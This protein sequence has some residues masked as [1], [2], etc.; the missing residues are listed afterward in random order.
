MSCRH[1]ICGTCMTEILKG[2]ADHRDAFLSADE[3]ACGKYM[4]PCVSR[5]TGTRIVLNL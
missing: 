4:L 2:K 1:G 3:H 5:A